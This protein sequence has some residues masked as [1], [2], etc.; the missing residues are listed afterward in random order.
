MERKQ[1]AIG[2]DLGGTKILTAL[3]D[4]NGNVVDR[5]EMPTNV[6]Q[7]GQ[8][9]IDRV[10]SSVQTILEQ[11][12]ENLP[13]IRGIGVATAGVIDTKTNSIIMASNLGLE[14]APIGR[15][16][17]ER[18]GLPVHIGNDANVAAVGEWVWGAGKGHQDVIYITVSTGIGAGIISGGKLVKGVGDS[19]G[20][21]GHISIDLNGPKCACGNYGCL[22]NYASGT[23]IANLARQKIEAGEKSRLENQDV[24]SLTAKQVAEA[25]LAG[26]ALAIRVF[27][28]AGY[29]IGAGIANLIHLFNPEII[30]IGGGVMNAE[31]VLLPAIRKTVK[32][33]CIPMMEKQARL[34]RAVLGPESGVKGAAGLVF[35]E[36]ADGS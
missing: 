32:D 8:V 2:I 1:L 7:G 11:N 16:I 20:E 33:R 23:A 18:F 34:V 36:Q 22:E 3:I 13:H 10:L 25:A 26:D 9:V 21:F 28:Q 17:E 30:V 35:T 29:Y 14:N 27:E 31:Q 24:S 5:T 6:E 19:A 4:D 15:F 12:Q